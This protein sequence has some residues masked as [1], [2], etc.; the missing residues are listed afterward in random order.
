MKEIKEKELKDRLKDIKEKDLKEGKE[1]KEGKEIKE[2]DKD[3]EGKPTDKLGEVRQF[4]TE[5]A[6]A[7]IEQRLAALEQAVQQLVHF[8]GQELRPDLSRSALQDKR[9]GG[10]G[11]EGPQGRREDVGRADRI[12]EPGGRAL[13]RRR[14]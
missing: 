2:K 1:F 8:I 12:A 6:A 9:T 5:A 11:R 10:E 4:A 7:P 13:A 3:F 14:C